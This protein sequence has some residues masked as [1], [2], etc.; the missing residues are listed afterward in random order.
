VIDSSGPRWIGPGGESVAHYGAGWIIAFHAYDALNNGSPTLQISDLYW[1]ADDWPSLTAPA[2]AGPP[3]FTTQPISVSVTGGTVALNAVATNAPTYQWRRNGSPVP[4]ATGPLLLIPDAANATG[5]YTCVATNEAGSAVSNPATLAVTAGPDAGRMVKL[6]CRA[7]VGTG[8][9]VLIA[10]FSVGGAGT[11]GAESLL[12]RAS[13]PALAAVPF[14]VAGTLADPDLQIDSLAG[15]QANALA[16]DAGWGGSASIAAAAASVGAFAWADPSSK[17]SA[18][19]TSLAGGAYTAE[20]SGTSGDTGVALAEVYDATPRGA[21]TP[22]TPRLINLSARVEVGTGGN[23]LIAGFV[24]GGSSARTVLVRASGPAIGAAPF[25]VPGTLADPQLMLTNLGTGAVAAS[26]DG[27]GG[28]PA[29]A[30]AAV[31][32]GAF[33]WNNP[34]SA[35]SAFLVTLPPGNYT[36]TVSGSSGDSGV[37]LVEVY[38]VQ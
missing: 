31:S 3:A 25:D 13:G 26:N 38:E 5:A 33:P 37:A 14:N 34:S 11:S 16:S 20:I 10:G 4:G 18:V 1:T 30:A 22:S 17:D 2:V 9:N 19:A 27:W 23:V 29:I 7:T 35:D 6:S 21:R 15:G 32:V 8:A 36:A 28:D 24:I 12:I